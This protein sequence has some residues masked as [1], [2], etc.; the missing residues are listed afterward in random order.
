MFKKK[1]KGDRVGMPSTPPMA[2]KEPFCPLF[3]RL[4]MQSCAWRIGG[5][6]AMMYAAKELYTLVETL[7]HAATDPATPSGEAQQIAPQ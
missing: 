4:C 5:E 2:L 1:D 7:G 3:A 6:C